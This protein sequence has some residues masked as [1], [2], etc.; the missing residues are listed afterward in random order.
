[1]G[2]PE[3]NR[4]S[5]QYCCMAAEGSVGASRHWSTALGPCR[6]DGS[7]WRTVT[8]ACHHWR[9]LRKQRLGGGAC[10]HAA[11]DSRAVTLRS[12][13][14]EWQQQWRC[15][16]HRV[17]VDARSVTTVPLAVELFSRI[18]QADS[19]GKLIEPATSGGSALYTLSMHNTDAWLRLTASNTRE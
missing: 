7:V 4:V 5:V 14:S 9:V 18:A 3:R 13:F 12:D 10:R 1:M 19:L 17:D 15:L 11:L 6:H 8:Y 2:L 16:W